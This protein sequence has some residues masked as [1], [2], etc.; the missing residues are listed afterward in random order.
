MSRAFRTVALVGRYQSEGVAMALLD[1]A[2]F[3]R[4]RDVRVLVEADTFEAIGRP[5]LDP[6]VAR[7]IIHTIRGGSVLYAD[8]SSD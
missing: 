4:E 6:A 2:R 7:P 3:L 1:I 8:G 5:A